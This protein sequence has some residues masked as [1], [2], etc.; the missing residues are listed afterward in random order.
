LKKRIGFST[1]FI[2]T[3]FFTTGAMT[4][5]KPSQHS[6]CYRCNDVRWASV[7]VFA[8]AFFAGAYTYHFAGWSSGDFLQLSL[9][10]SPSWS[11]KSV[12]QVYIATKNEETM[13]PHTVKHYRT[14]FPGCHITVYDNNSTD[15]TVQLAYSLGCTVRQRY[16]RDNMQDEAALAE[17]K[18]N[19]WKQ[20]YI[21]GRDPPWVIVVDADE[22]LDVW[23]SDLVAEDARGSV[24]V[25][26]EGFAAVGRSQRLDLA[27]IDLHAIRFGVPGTGLTANDHDQHEQARNWYSKSVCFKRGR[28]G[29]SS[30]TYG[31]GAH[32][33]T[34][35]PMNAPRSAAC[36]VLKHMDAMGEL[37]LVEKHKRRYNQTL[38]SRAQGLD[39]HYLRN[40]NDVVQLYRSTVNASFEWRTLTE[41]GRTRL[42]CSY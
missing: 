1:L 10:A 8:V 35:I 15:K 17:T 19:C 31:L 16:T 33:A 40:R 25:T 9:A 2:H 30:M 6:T 28:H 29:L 20:D 32:T 24:I 7:V 23:E 41:D 36:Y 39:L 3:S 38:H 21:E 26:T 11:P 18:S 14:R 34:P 22:W 13:L 27:D 12:V 4:H 42:Q 5:N 37:Y